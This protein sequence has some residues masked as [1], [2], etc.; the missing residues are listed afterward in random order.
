MATSY[1]YQ[2]DKQIRKVPSKSCYF[3]YNENK[4]PQGKIVIN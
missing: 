2:H 1:A 3:T 4:Q